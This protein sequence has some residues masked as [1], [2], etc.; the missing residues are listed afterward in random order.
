MVTTLHASLGA[1]P[2]HGLPSC[3]TTTT[4]PHQLPCQ[5]GSPSTRSISAWGPGGL[6]LALLSEEGQ[7]PQAWLLSTSHHSLDLLLGPTDH[8]HC[9]SPTRPLRVGGTPWQQLPFSGMVHKA[10]A[11]A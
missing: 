11:T 8:C 2:Q 5:P 3:S 4:C 10:A 1:D 6:R 9:H 7:G